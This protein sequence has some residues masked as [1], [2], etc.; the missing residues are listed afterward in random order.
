MLK[1]GDHAVVLGASMGGLLAARV[2]ADAYQRVTVVDRDLLPAG[3]A[4]RQGVPQGR[5]AH[6][7]LA[8]G[9]QILDELLPGL[10]AEMAAAEVP[11]LSSP[12]E[13]WFST[14][15][16]LL[17][18]DGDPADPAYLASRPYL[19]AQVRRRVRALGNVSVKDQCAV[20]SRGTDPG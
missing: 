10:L 18:R 12:R 15:G 1:I 19:E 5:H 7:L 8:R 16:H 4:D 6:A 14:V 9:A 3:A 17:C 2:L 11:A 20:T 13:M